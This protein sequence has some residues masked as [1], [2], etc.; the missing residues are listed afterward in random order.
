MLRRFSVICCLLLTYGAAAMP[1]LTTV[2]HGTYRYL[3]WQLYDARLA[4]NDGTFSG[5]QQSA[6]LMLALTY[7]RNIDREQIIAATVEQWQSLD[8]S[9]Q[10]QQAQW[11]EQL[12]AVWQ[13]VSKG[14][15]LA[16]LLQ[17]DGSVTFYLNGSAIGGMSDKA[18][19]EAF[20][21]IWLHPD[22][23][24]PQLRRALIAAP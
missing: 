20:F 3:F 14:D 21:N 17:P 24:A 13:D 16:A 12:R 10:T 15:T 19:G 11:A 9:T 1:E 2:G 8:Q 4:T 6:P 22:T 18:F 5:Y 23:S 7:K